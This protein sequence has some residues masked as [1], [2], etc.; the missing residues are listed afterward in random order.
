ME[1]YSVGYDSV[2]RCSVWEYRDGYSAY[3]IIIWIVILLE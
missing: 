2:L 3:R 1:N